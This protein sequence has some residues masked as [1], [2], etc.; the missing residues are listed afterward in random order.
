MTLPGDA[1]FV[2]YLGATETYFWLSNPTRPKHFALAAQVS[3]GTTVAAWQR[4][5]DAVQDRHRLL[6]VT[7]SADETGTPYF[8][9]LPGCRIPLRVLDGLRPH[10]WEREMETE[11][12][13]PLPLEDALLVRATLIHEAEAATVI[14]TMH[15]AIGDGL[16]VALIVRDML[17]ALSGSELAALPI[18][19]AQEDLCTHPPA[20]P[21]APPA[22]APRPAR[23]A[24]RLR[25]ALRV[26]SLRLSADVTDHLRT[27]CRGEQATV[28][29]ALVAAFVLAGRNRCAAWDDFA[30]RVVSP[31]NNRPRLDRGDAC[32]LSILAPI[33][34]YDPGSSVEFWGIARAVRSDL[35]SV[36]TPAGLA[37]SFA[38]F[39]QLIAS[40][41]GVEGLAQFELQACASEVM[42]SN[43]G[44]WPYAT[45][46]GQLRLTSLW[47]PA[48]LIGLEG[49]QMIG[50]ATIDRQLHLLHTSYSPIV[51]LLDGAVGEI[52][53]AIGSPTGAVST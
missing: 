52:L 5:L 22:S 4:A 21:P 40:E 19:P 34:A 14:L 46:F 24:A 53:A 37:A 31:V 8:R 47:G 1:Q 15:H 35:A 16:S 9:E 13:T 18:P 7:I 49:E 3:G 12:F 32:A 41:P 28:H 36:R 11:L 27:R 39:Q 20:S 2:R 50:V 38:A 26:Q 45:N 43:L 23:S 25:S 42:V 33:S 51:G 6:R 48:V 29:G 44:A 17:S 30:V 10:S